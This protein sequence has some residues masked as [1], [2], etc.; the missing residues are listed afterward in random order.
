MKLQI[1]DNFFYN[2]KDSLMVEFL[3]SDLETV[4]YFFT[5]GGYQHPDDIK[6]NKKLLKAYKRILKY[7][8][9]TND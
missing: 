6:Y 2:L 7:Y 8:G 3:K 1:D 4:K 5:S 9:V